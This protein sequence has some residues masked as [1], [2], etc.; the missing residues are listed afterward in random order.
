VLDAVHER[1]GP[2]GLRR[3]AELTNRTIFTDDVNLDYL[4]DRGEERDD[5][6]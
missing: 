4:G 6:A 2:G 1:F 5:D 3:A